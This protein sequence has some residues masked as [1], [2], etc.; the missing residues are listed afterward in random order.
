MDARWLTDDEQR[1][2]R[3]L[4]GVLEL[5][6]AALD[7]QLVRDAGL[8]HFDYVTLAMLSEAPD[9]TLRM[10][11]LAGRTNATLARLSNV[12]R[13]LEGRGLV[14]RVPC[15]EDRRA[16][17]VVLTDDGLATVVAAAPGHVEQVRCLVFDTLDPEQVAQLTVIAEQLLGRL[18][19]DHRMVDLGQPSSPVES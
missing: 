17:N 12:V 14:G 6:P 7:S 1:A 19:P 3:R 2:W 5:L 18:D 10:T 16:T 13:R 15:P 9:R 8:T 11:T 4:S